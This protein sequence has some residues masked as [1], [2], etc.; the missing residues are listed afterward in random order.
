MPQ[1]ASN[2][3][4]TP[5]HGERRSHPTNE[6]HVLLVSEKIG[7]TELL[8]VITMYIVHSGAARMQVVQAN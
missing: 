1:H 8:D 3:K 4:F 2:L 6:V 7:K 5:D